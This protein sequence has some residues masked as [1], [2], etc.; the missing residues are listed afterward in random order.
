MS[1]IS[2]KIHDHRSFTLLASG[3]TS[4][5]SYR[6]G[7]VETAHLY[8]WDFFILPFNEESSQQC[9]TVTHQ[10]EYS[11]ENDAIFAELLIK[12][13]WIWSFHFS[14]ISLVCRFLSGE[15]KINVEHSFSNLD[16]ALWAESHMADIKPQ[17]WW[18]GGQ[19]WWCTH[20]KIVL[21]FCLII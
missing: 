7:N 16:F 17:M 13:E 19:R 15:E 2:A 18:R 4:K 6:T 12:Q 21:L 9:D 5:L 11:R 20:Y 1:K 10:M 3:Y 8:I 14:H